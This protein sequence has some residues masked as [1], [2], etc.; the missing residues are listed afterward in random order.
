LPEGT[1]PLRR[2]EFPKKKWVLKVRRR[3]LRVNDGPPR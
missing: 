2:Y 1:N 3:S